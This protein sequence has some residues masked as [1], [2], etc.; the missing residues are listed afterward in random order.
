M[1]N[2]VG[3][4]QELLLSRVGDDDAGR[5]IMALL[6]TAR[7]IDAACAD[8]LAKHDLSEGRLAALLAIS[9]EPGVS[10]G[11][12]AERLQVTRATV[13][14]LLDGLERHALV[15][16]GGSVG[17][18]RSLTLRA[19]LTGED[20][21]TALTPKYSG[22]LHQIGSGISADDHQVVLRAMTAIQRNLGEGAV[23]G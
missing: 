8:L 13:T 23:D 16:R 1:N 12:L 7:R 10:P 21:I 20:L 5:L 6:T 17:D 2:L 11:A 4:K 19:T 22:W 14:G 18:R 3:V 15:E 9:A